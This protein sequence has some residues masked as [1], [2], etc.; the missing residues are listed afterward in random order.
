[1]K[2]PYLEKK[3]KNA[4][5]ELRSRSLFDRKKGGDWANMVDISS[6]S[7]SPSSQPSSMMLSPLK[8]IWVIVCT[9][10]S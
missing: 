9:S 4:V 2:I 10:Y 3:K 6:R 7:R 8:P 5:E 1:M